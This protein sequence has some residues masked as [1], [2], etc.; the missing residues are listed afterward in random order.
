MALDQ[1]APGSRVTV[2]IT[3]RPT[4]R[5]AVKTLERLLAK[6]PEAKKETRRQEKVRKA[7]FRTHQRGGRDWEVRVPRQ[8]VVDVAVGEQ[9]TITA[10]LDVLQDL[11][12]VERFVEVSK[13]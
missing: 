11:R 3:T 2:K 4:N 8:P 1:I 7:G 9:G 5:A 12:S 10:S 6:S 13:A